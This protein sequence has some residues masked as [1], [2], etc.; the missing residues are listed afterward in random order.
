MT[1]S[2]M[3]R[4]RWACEAGVVEE[5][6]ST[7]LGLLRSIDKLG[8]MNSAQREIMATLTVENREKVINRVMRK[9]HGQLSAPNH[10]SAV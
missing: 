3:Q 6:L 10:L 2:E 1:E 9:K 8:G 4:A 5:Q 7:A